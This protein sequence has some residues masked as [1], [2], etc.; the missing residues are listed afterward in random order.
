M[1]CMLGKLGR[2]RTY[3]LFPEISET[4]TYKQGSVAVLV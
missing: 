4:R 2:V 1:Y 3:S